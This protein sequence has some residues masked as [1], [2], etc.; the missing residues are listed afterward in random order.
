MIAII[1]DDNSIRELVCYTLNRT[2]FNSIGFESPKEFWKHLQENSVELVL[3]DI[4]LPD[5]DGI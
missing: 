3:L 5:E 4:M 2:G 1:E